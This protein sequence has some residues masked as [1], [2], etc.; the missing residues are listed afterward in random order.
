MVVNGVISDSAKKE[1]CNSKV[2]PDIFI[3]FIK[4]LLFI[5]R[6]THQLEPIAVA[7]R[8]DVGNVYYLCN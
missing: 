1:I 2:I 7:R 4:N 3:P 5:I 8:F 6:C